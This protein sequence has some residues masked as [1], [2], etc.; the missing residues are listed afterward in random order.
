LDFYAFASCLSEIATPAVPG[1][2]SR[3]IEHR[4]LL[5]LAP[6]SEDSDTPSDPAHPGE[7]EAEEEGVAVLTSTM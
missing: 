3:I 4:R 6:K 2:V 1:I 5:E 7:G